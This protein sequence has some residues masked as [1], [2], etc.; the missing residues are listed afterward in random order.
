M[1]IEADVAGSEN[2]WPGAELLAMPCTLAASW[3]WVYPDRF[4]YSRAAT[5][6][7][8]GIEFWFY[9]GLF[10]LLS[11]GFLVWAAI[12]RRPLKACLV[13]IG[14]CVGGVV[15][16]NENPHHDVYWRQKFFKLNRGMTLAIF[17]DKTVLK[18]GERRS[19][20]L[21]EFQD[22]AYHGRMVK[23]RNAA[24]ST[25]FIFV[26]YVKDERGFGFAWSEGDAPPPKEAYP[27][28]YETKQLMPG[29]YMFWSNSPP[30]Y[31][32]Q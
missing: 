25:W 21:T 27:K 30:L 23:Y 2:S 7:S 16:S 14:I 6:P 19:I 28:I 15:Y 24:G 20:P 3:F 9:T 32:P 13:F 29:W 22:H 12:H 11:I 8:V 17:D 1:Q 26:Q 5:M 4:P 10:V 31:R 18:P